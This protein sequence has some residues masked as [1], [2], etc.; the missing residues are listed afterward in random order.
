MKTTL[1]IAALASAVL[2]PLALLIIFLLFRKEIPL[3][4]K[5]IS[6]R[7][8]K[9]EFAGVSLELAKADKFSPNWIA[10]GALDLRQ[11]AE[12]MM[13]NDSAASNFSSQLKEGGSADYVIVNLGEGEEWLTSR[14]YILAIIFEKMKGIKGVVFLETA[15][16]IR[17]RFVGWAEPQKIRWTFAQQFPWF[18]TAY[19]DAY[20]NTIST[21]SIVSSQGKLGYSHELNNPHPSIDLL[22]NFLKKIQSPPEIQPLPENEKE[23]VN[24]SSI[25]NT[26]EHTQWLNAEKL[27]NLLGE[28]LIVESVKSENQNS[29]DIEKQIKKCLTFSNPFIAVVKEDN[30]FDFLVKQEKLLEQI[31][32]K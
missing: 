3:L 11:K 8:T 7:L 27:E 6:G 32:A 10:D 15:T 26:L 28:A 9:L 23:W 12:A 18:E 1:D 24:L 21:A 17:K 5:S 13:V 30:R 4:L 16:G 31:L 25:N 22:Q 14:L 29:P 2:Y 20:S 19:A